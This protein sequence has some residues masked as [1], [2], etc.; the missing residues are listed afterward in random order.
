M[1]IDFNTINLASATDVSQGKYV[2]NP[3]V[4]FDCNGKI[5]SWEKVNEVPRVIFGAMSMIIFALSMY[6]T[7]ANKFMENYMFG[8]KSWFAV[9]VWMLFIMTWFTSFL[10]MIFWWL[11]YTQVS[12]LLDIFYWVSM[13]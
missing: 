3:K 7:F 11:S 4:D 9:G 1:S 8:S 12:I 5:E 2:C 10:E 13:V 6:S